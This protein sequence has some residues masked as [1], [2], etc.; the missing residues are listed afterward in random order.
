MPRAFGRRPLPVP[1]LLVQA[2]QI[3]ALQIQ[4]PQI[5]ALLVPAL[6]FRQRELGPD[7]PAPPGRPWSAWLAPGS[8]PG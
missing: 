4:A 1:A 8:W 7:R 6:P 5:T 2:L 3:Q